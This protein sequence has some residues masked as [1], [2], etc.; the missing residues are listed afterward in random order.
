MVELVE[1]SGES[2]IHKVSAQLELTPNH[3]HLFYFWKAHDL[4]LTSNQGDWQSSQFQKSRKHEL[5]KHT[6]FEAFLRPSGLNQYFEV[7]ISP[8]L[9]WNVYEFESYRAPQPPRESEALVPEKILWKDCVLEA[10]FRHSWTTGISLE[11]SLCS[12]LK[13]SDQTFYFSQKH[14]GQKPDF[15][16]PESFSLKRKIL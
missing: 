11:A 14:E 6:C 10:H 12:I 2:S 8:G 7:N 13:I 15:H 16:Q 9:G 3:L 5:W 4:N 1:F